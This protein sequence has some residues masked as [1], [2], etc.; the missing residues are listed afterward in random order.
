M[1]KILLA[2]TIFIKSFLTNK[3]L[4]SLMLFAKGYSGYYRSI[5]RGLLYILVN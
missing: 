3:S 5:R 2:F 1:L 4:F